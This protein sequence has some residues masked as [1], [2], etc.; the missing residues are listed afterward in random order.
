[1]T[2]EILE[3]FAGLAGA[4]LEFNHDPGMLKA[5]RYPAFLKA[6]VRGPRGHLSNGE[7]ADFLARVNH[8]G[9]KCVVL[10]H[11]SRNNNLP[12]LALEAAGAAIRGGPGAP[13]LEVASHDRP[14]RVF[15]L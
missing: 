12:E 4:V 8:P 5:G 1:V 2:G 6:R 10:G 11:L 7:G 13:V 9:L 14:T 15:D 3:A